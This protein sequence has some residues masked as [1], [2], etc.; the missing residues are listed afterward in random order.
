MG[1]FVEGPR[2]KVVQF[3]KKSANRRIAYHPT[4]I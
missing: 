1:T 4:T 2:S 3:E